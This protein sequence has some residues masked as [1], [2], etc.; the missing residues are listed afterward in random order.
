MSL[1]AMTRMDAFRV[2]Y[3]ADLE[4]WLWIEWDLCRRRSTDL[5]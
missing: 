4:K 5:V 1:G 2:W 3:I